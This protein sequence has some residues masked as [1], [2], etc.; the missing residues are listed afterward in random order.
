M[1]V[2]K[3]D[4]VGI[5]MD[6]FPDFKG[7]VN[8]TEHLVMEQSVFCLPASVRH[9]LPSSPLHVPAS[10]PIPLK[11]HLHYIFQAFEYPNFF[12]IVV[13]VPEEMMVEA[14][15][16]IR[17]F[18]QRHYRPSSCNSNDLDQWEVSAWPVWQHSPHR[19]QRIETGELNKCKIRKFHQKCI[20]P[21]LEV[22]AVKKKSVSII[23]TSSSLLH[24]KLWQQFI[25]WCDV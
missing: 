18:C 22:R 19:D 5:E 20:P 25:W 11:Y 8:F 15:G 3:L 17:E 13:T 24:Q 1:F 12:R 7:D 16:R 14:C 21:F 6:H 2:L 23:L 4:Q 10:R 9:K